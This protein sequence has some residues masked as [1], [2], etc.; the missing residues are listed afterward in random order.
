MFFSNKISVN[1]SRYFLQQAFFLFSTL[2][3]CLSNISCDRNRPNRNKSEGGVVNSAFE[4]RIGERLSHWCARMQ[5]EQIGFFDC[6]VFQGESKLFFNSKAHQKKYSWLAKLFATRKEKNSSKK[7]FPA[8][9]QDWEGLFIPGNYFFSS[10]LATDT[11]IKK[12]SFLSKKDSR[13]KEA[14]KVAREIL[15]FLLLRSKTRYTQGLEEISSTRDR[16]FSSLSSPLFLTLYEKMILASIIEK[17]AASNKD[18]HLVASVFYNRLQKKMPL[19]SCPTLEYILGYH[20]PFLLYK[21]LEIES[22]YNVYKEIGLP[23]SPISSFSQKAWEAALQ[24]ESRKIKR[25][26]LFFV[27]DWTKGLLSFAESY[28]E[29]K[30]NAAKARKN[31]ILKYG[32][33]K[34]YEKNN[35]FYTN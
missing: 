7:K 4:I 15:H 35:N 33:E 14:S 22:P 16:A 18:Y 1:P 21:D 29:H 6:A 24:V 13:K 17:E 19:G 11:N 5:K 30:K 32:K 12:K 23:P 3:L 25:A 9:W 28:E 8:D 27:Y 20:R 2:A 26:Y 10:A 34:L 31:F